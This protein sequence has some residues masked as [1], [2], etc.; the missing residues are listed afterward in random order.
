VSM[1]AVAVGGFPSVRARRVVGGGVVPI[2]IKAQRLQKLVAMLERWAIW[3]ESYRVNL[4]FP[5]SAVV[6]A[7]GGSDMV[8]SSEQ[9]DREERR[10]CEV[11]DAV[12]GDLPPACR[13]A[14]NQRYGLAPQAVRFN[15]VSEVEVLQHA[16]DMLMVALSKKGIDI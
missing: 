10:Q 13:A 3:C 8:R 2:D 14:V 15:R 4:G 6:L 11:V 1:R 5:R 7:T 12:V 16:H 9:S